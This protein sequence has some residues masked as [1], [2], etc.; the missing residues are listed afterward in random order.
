[1]K[2]QPDEAVR[3]LKESLQRGS[4]SFLG[5]YNYARERYQLT[6][7]AR[8]HYSPLEKEAAAEI[9][10]E[11]QKAIGLMPDFGPAH[12]LLGFFEMVQGTDLAMAEQQ[13]E[14]AIELEPGNQWYLLSLAQ[15][16]L[17]ENKLDA[18]RQT[19]QPLRLPYVENKL[20][21]QAEQMFQRIDRQA[22]H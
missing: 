6:A 17:V 12:E 15:A 21:T 11:L 2:K 13:L 3:W 5:H 16:Q 4:T 1:M 10:A 9:R 8:E 18:A 14:Q 7:D 22:A 20:R 19:L